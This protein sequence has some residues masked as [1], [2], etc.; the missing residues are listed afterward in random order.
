MDLNAIRMF[1]VV[2]TKG[3]FTRAARVLDIPVATVSR[4][5]AMLE[6]QLNVRLLERST[7]RLRLTTAGKILH[8]YVKRGVDEFEAG[9]LALQEQQHQMA[10][11]IRVSIP[12]GFLPM[13]TLLREF[14]AE[15]PNVEMSV[16]A[17][18][19]RVDFIEDGIDVALRIGDRKSASAIARNLGAYR[20]KLV[21]AP[22]LLERY[23]VRQPEDLKKVPCIAWGQQDRD[24]V[25]L[26]G[27]QAIAV[28]P[29]LRVNDYLHLRSMVVTGGW[30]TELPPFLCSDELVEV[31]PENPLPEQR[32]SLL[33]PSNRNLS[34]ITRVFIDFIA[35][36]LHAALEEGSSLSRLE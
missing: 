28:T 23:Q 4:R 7:R 31:L 26:L 9:L 12:L 25:W 11:L 32:L 20:H 3:S 34:R 33:Y 6:I 17:T 24:I 1:S 10:G 22:A 16:F 15:F 36:N 35:R 30:V 5:V 21:A 2:A 29:K 18:E 13:W 8:E 14:Q 19:R 27:T